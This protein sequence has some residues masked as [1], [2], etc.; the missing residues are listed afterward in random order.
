MLM[1]IVQPITQFKGPNGSKFTWGTIGF[2]NFLVAGGDNWE[3]MHIYNFNSPKPANSYTGFNSDVT[4]IKFSYDESKVYA[5]TFGGTLF[6]YNHDRGKISNTLRGHLTHCRWVTDQKEELANY[7]VSGAADTNVKV[8]D[9]RQ[10]SAIATYK[11]HNKAITS[12]DISPDTA[13]VASGCTGGVVKIWDLTSGKCAYT[14]DVN[15]KSSSENCFIKD[16]KFNPADWC[17]AVACSDKII[18]YYDTTTYEL[19]NESS[20]DVHPLNNVEFDP[21]GETVIAAHTDSIKVWDLEQR[22]LISM[23][24]KTAR[25]VF[26]M[27][28]TWDNDFT[29]LLEN[30]SGSMGL[31]QISTSLIT[32]RNGNLADYEEVKRP[33]SV[34]DNSNGFNGINSPNNRINDDLFIPGIN[35]PTLDFYKAPNN[36]PNVPSGK[37]LNNGYDYIYGLEDSNDL[38]ES[39]E[40]STQSPLINKENAYPKSNQAAQLPNKLTKKTKSRKK[41]FCNNA[42]AVI[43]KPEEEKRPMLGLPTKKPSLNSKV[44]LEGKSINQM[45]EVNPPK[46][47]NVV[48]SNKSP[49]EGLSLLTEEGLKKFEMQLNN[50]DD[51]STI[52]SEWTASLY[53][54]PIDKPWGLNLEKFLNNVSHGI[55]TTQTFGTLNQAPPIEVQRKIME[56]V[57]KS[58]KTMLSVMNSR[59][60]HLENVKV[61]WELGDLSKTLNALVINKDTSAVMDFINNSFVESDDGTNREMIRHNI[62]GIKITNCGALLSH[63]YTL[64]NSKYETYLICGIKALKVVFQTI[65][66]IIFKCRDDIRNGNEVAG[67]IK[68]EEK[69]R[70]LTILMKQLT[71]IVE[72]K[73]IAKGRLRQNKSGELIRDIIP[74]IELFISTY[75]KAPLP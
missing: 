13:F 38:D 25:P 63:I 1:S 53:E 20:A 26:D 10:K 44:V 16:I 39:S 23:V 62:Q 67:E 7:V 46:K 31:S 48:Q 60:I 50:N 12:V 55:T 71:K 74:D 2:K 34:P 54:V 11:G 66:E 9:L 52:R 33:P 69:G 30:V 18:R 6:V 61:N 47:P 65:S 49:I 28:V 75:N 8:W 35:N 3:S 5:G 17:M 22:K 43:S 27:K 24:S 14:F 29:F 32:S 73:G 59:R 42:K 36:E 37:V 45:I 56:D 15:A 57:I 58:N 40:S 19:I 4:C 72:S 41:V 21:D 51:I 68:N 64:L 70:R